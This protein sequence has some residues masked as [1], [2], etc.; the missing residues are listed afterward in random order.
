[1]YFL[2]G[3]LSSACQSRSDY[4]LLTAGVSLRQANSVDAKSRSDD[5]SSVVPAG[6]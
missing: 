1:M 2:A 3:L 5:T 6:L 4:T